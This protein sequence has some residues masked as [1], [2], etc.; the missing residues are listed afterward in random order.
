MSLLSSPLLKERVADSLSRCRRSLVTIY[1]CSSFT[2]SKAA[3][4]ALISFSIG[5]VWPVTVVDAS[6]VERGSMSY[7]IWERTGVS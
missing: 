7:S 6:G 1:S 2:A 5:A 4:N 3:L